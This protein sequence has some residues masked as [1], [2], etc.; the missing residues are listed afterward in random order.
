[1]VLSWAWTITFCRQ[2]KKCSIIWRFEELWRIGTG[3]LLEFSNWLFSKWLNPNVAIRHIGFQLQS[4]LGNRKTLLSAKS[5]NLFKLILVWRK[6]IIQLVLKSLFNLN[7]LF[8]LF[9]SF[10]PHIIILSNA[11][12]VNSKIIKHVLLRN[13]SRL[14]I[15]N[16]KW[17]LGVSL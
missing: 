16:P 3:L 6:I 10:V 8:Y 9:E 12:S 11:W 1:M 5:S 4:L 2:S 14:W 13:D 15:F 7:F 17:K